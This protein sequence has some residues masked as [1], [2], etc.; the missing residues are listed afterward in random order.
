MKIIYCFKIWQHLPLAIRAITG[1]LPPAYQQSWNEENFTNLPVVKAE[2]A[3]VGDKSCSNVAAVSQVEQA[4]MLQ[5]GQQQDENYFVSTCIFLLLIHVHRTFFFLDTS[6]VS[7]INYLH[8][9]VPNSTQ[10]NRNWNSFLSCSH[11]FLLYIQ[12]QWIV[13]SLVFQVPCEQSKK[14]WIFPCEQSVWSFQQVK[15]SPDA[16][17]MYT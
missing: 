14:Y 16:M 9:S 4:A 10:S 6:S 15:N 12:K 8:I 17:W 7:S 1:L 13:N 5:T 11:L 3:S 2:I